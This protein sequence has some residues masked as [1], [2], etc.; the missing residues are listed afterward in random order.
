LLAGHPGDYWVD[1][2]FLEALPALRSA[3]VAGR[4]LGLV[5]HYLPSLVTRGV[6]WTPEN[7]T[8][9]ERGALAASD[10][11]LV[12]SRFMARTL[13]RI[14]HAPRH[15]LV[16]EPGVEA[17]SRSPALDEATC[18]VSLRAVLRAVMVANVVEG[19]GILPFLSVLGK[20]VEKETP[21]ALTVIG[22]LDADPIYSTSCRSLVSTVSALRDK[23]RFVGAL[24]QV[25]AL[26]WLER[27]DV[28]V[29]ASRME[30]F[31]MALSEA[32]ALGVPILSYRGGNATAHVEASA[33]GGL[34]D[35]D[36]SLARALAALSRDPVDLSARRRCARAAMRA[37]SWDAAAR[38]F[39]AEMR[40]VRSSVLPEIR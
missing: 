38:D 2:L 3:N 8:Q 35:D 13:A 6:H 39:A 31:G 5:L 16:V 40:R 20:I 12:T 34:F 24:P 27:S 17:V 30:S 4:R 23:V 14:A 37:R 1:S 28:L 36:F 22:D 19:K 21:L 9:A 32:R 18:A 33:G 7:A 10:V 15:I 26:A 29:S 11:A 25:E